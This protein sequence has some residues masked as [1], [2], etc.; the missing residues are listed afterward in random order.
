V[1]WPTSGAS[2]GVIS[3]SW[4]RD[5][6]IACACRARYYAL[7]T[8]NQRVSRYSSAHAEVQFV[9]DRRFD[10]VT[11]RLALSQDRRG[12][13]KSAAAIFGITAASATVTRDADAA[14]R[15]YSG[16]ALGT[17]NAQLWLTWAHHEGGGGVCD[18]V[19]NFS[20]FLPDTLV[21]VTV[22]A[23]KKGG[24][25]SGAILYSTSVVT[26]S[27]G[28]ATAY[29]PAGSL[30]L[31]SGAFEARAVAGAIVSSDWSVGSC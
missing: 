5:L 16:P 11:K 25:G 12:F 3:A 4:I 28:A 31:F 14:R 21:P 9:N 20:G 6:V 29:P 23:R 30:P 26:D 18:A 27:S 19:V 2:L 7:Q 17:A 8:Y 24:S 1:P 13:L 22:F 10:S 15:G